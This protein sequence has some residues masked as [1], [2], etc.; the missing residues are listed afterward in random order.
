MAYTT[1]L[2]NKLL[3]HVLNNTPYTSPT[4]VY[5]ALFTTATTDAGG[6]TEA[7]GGSYARQV[8]VYS[9][10]ATK[11][12]DNT[13][14]VTFTN[15]PAA[16]FTHGAMYDAVSGGNML[17]H[18]ALAAPIVTTAGQNLNFAIADIDATVG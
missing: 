3:D 17:L 6:G 16:T 2:A 18:G 13:G 14:I 1:Y 5:F 12:S 10:A 7:V 11:H 4:T 9:A 8:V 15:M